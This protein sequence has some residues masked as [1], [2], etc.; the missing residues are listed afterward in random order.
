MNLQRQTGSYYTPKFL[1]DF[2]VRWI[3]K[4][5]Y[6]NFSNI[7]EP[8]AGDGI[9][10][11]SLINFIDIK[12]HKVN[13]DLVEINESASSN[14]IS[15]FSHYPNITIS[16]SDFLDYQLVCNKNYSLVIGNPPYVK[17]SYL[18]DE[19]ILLSKKIFE[20]YQKLTNSNLKNI[21]SSF[22]V[23]SIS[24]L[25][26]DGIL[27]F[28]LPAELLQVDYAAQLRQLLLSEFKRI[29]VFTFNELLF[30]ECKGQDTIIL[31]AYKKA[32][33]EGLFFSNIENTYL[34]K[35]LEKITF[36]EHS[37]NEK[38]WSSHSLN[39]NELNLINNLISNCITLTDVSTSKPGIVTA[40]NKFFIL[41][42]S[43]VLKYNLEKY[44]KKIVQKGSFVGDKI[45][46]DE[47]DFSNIQTNDLPCY[48]IDLNIQELDDE[49][50][51]ILNYLNLGLEQKLHQ[52]YK[53]QSRQKW[54]QVP[55]KAEA[56]PLFFFKRCH[57][58][59]KLI[60][61]FS[62]SFTTDSAYLVTPNK[63]FKADSIL[64]SFYNSFTLVCA[65]LMGRY[66]GGGVLELTPN[67]FKKL[68]LPYTEISKSDFQTYLE[69]HHIKTN[70]NEILLKYNNMILKAY[71]PDI[72]DDDIKLL[73]QIRLKLV[74]RRHRL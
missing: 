45:T 59:P 66:Y 23:R 60:R 69:L 21:W 15:K 39:S 72:R 22:L 49:N 14:L 20:S 73:E 70:I 65:E 28:V 57:N 7:L 68:P 25:S 55:Y 31:I 61:N 9:F 74:K 16:N 42:H 8:S 18:T 43:D 5:P 71:F 46:F 52:R 35:D 33:N 67:E 63:Q 1:S 3:I 62:S 26:D 37:I 4:H 44:T 40:A 38:K 34:L 41:N 32:D 13:I 50:P 27:A 47:D 10:V 29:E 30:K 51:D 17:R 19:Q 6:R 56:T 12:E 48:F 36:T 64:F 54:F 53:M 2:I 58:Y 11:D 24:L